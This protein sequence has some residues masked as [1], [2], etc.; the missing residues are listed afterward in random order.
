METADMQELIANLLKELYKEGFQ[1]DYCRRIDTASKANIFLGIDVNN[2]PY[3]RFITCDDDKERIRSIKPKNGFHIKQEA[4][5]LKDYPGC[6]AYRISKGKSVDTDMFLSFISDLAVTAA[7]ED[8]GISSL[9]SRLIQW[10]VFFRNC[11]EGILSV[12]QQIGLYGELN[13]ALHFVQNGLSGIINH[14]KGPDKA[15]KDYIFQDTAVEVK[16]TLRD[17]KNRIQISNEFQ[18]DAEGFDKLFLYFIIVSED[19]IEGQTLPEQIDA[20]RYYLKND[21]HL[22][23]IFED[24]LKKAGYEESFRDRYTT[25]FVSNSSFC[26]EVT[27]EFPRIT[28]KNLVHGISSVSY[29]IDIAACS[30]FQWTI[31]DFFQSI[32]ERIR[33]EY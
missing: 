15:A 24:L 10:S 27:P 22:I 30:D 28:P 31:P 26:Y 23:N 2:E 7:Q 29:M 21:L 5:A 11:P 16:T 33:S 18:L 4:L 13:F 20:I 25:R 12:K 3:F 32:S 1:T 17:D 6:T 8:S 9:I 19:N 14:W